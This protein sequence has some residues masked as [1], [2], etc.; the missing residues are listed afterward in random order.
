M[1]RP[2]PVI[3]R[4]ESSSLLR[5][6]AQWF[7]G[8]ANQIEVI[9]EDSS[10]DNWRGPYHNEFRSLLSIMAYPVYIMGSG[11]G[12][13][14]VPEMDTKVFPLI[15]GEGLRLKTT[16]RAVRWLLGLN[17]PDLKS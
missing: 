8:A 10:I 13:L 17:I 11:R 14:F 15:V 16:R 9:G 1:V 6:T 3:E 7:G 2:T 12:S 5:S 4:F